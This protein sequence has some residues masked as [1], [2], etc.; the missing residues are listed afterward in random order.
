VTPLRG[1]SLV[2]YG[3]DQVGGVSYLS[4]SLYRS[5]YA[6]CSLFRRGVRSEALKS[7]YFGFEREE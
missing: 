1:S 2:G 4:A 7:Q 3:S 6:G 5:D